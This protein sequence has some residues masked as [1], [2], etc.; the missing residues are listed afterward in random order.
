M[1]RFNKIKIEQELTISSFTANN[2]VEFLDKDYFIIYPNSNSTQCFPLIVTL[3]VYH[4]FPCPKQVDKQDFFLVNARRVLVAKG[5]DKIM[6]LENP[7]EQELW[8]MRG[9]AKIICDA[10]RTSN[11]FFYS[12]GSNI[13]ALRMYAEQY[14][15]LFAIRNTLQLIKSL[16][17]IY[18]RTNR[19]AISSAWE[20]YLFTIGVGDSFHL[21][22]KQIDRY[23]L[24]MASNINTLDNK[25]NE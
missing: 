13:E 19:E 5:F 11:A 4:F 9:R 2:L 7:P 14:I 25:K 1:H 15:F 21:I 8:I 12:K 10:R 24:R 3:E 16:F 23:S 18:K 17:S 6:I 20:K 22:S